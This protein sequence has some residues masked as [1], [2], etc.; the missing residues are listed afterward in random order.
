LV[1]HFTLVPATWGCPAHA[2]MPPHGGCR[3]MLGTAALPPCTAVA[4]TVEI[5]AS[6]IESCTLPSPIDKPHCKYY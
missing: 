6:T 2:V 1:W 3:D 4:V 5:D